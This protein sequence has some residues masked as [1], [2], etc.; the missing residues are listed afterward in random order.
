MLLRLYIKDFTIVDE[1][2]IEFAPGF[3]VITG[4]TGAGKSILVG[5]LGLL[6]GDRGNADLI[7]AGAAKAVLEAEFKTGLNK[8]VIDK[9]TGLQITDIEKAILVRREISTKGSSRAFINDTPVTLND[10]GSITAGLLDLHGQHQH[11]RLIHPEYH[12]YYLDAFNRVKPELDKYTVAY[13]NYFAGLEELNT[14]LTLRKTSFEKKDLY[15]FQIDELG[16]ASLDE[17]ELEKLV[18]ERR[19]M[20]NSEQLFELSK[21]VADMLYSNEDA[22]NKKITQAVSDLGKISAIDKQF[23]ELVQGLESARV[24]IEETG[25][26]CEQY[27]STLEFDP[28]RLET[29][30]TRETE[31]NWLLK[32]YQVE[33]V[34]DLIQFRDK[35]VTYMAMLENYDERIAALQQDIEKNRIELQSLAL[36]ISAYRKKTAKQF[37]Q[38]LQDLFDTVGLKK[39]RFQVQI[40]WQ[41]DEQGVVAE[42]GKR[43]AV[44]PLGMDLIEFYVGMN[45]G[46]PVR[47]LH[48]VASGGEISRIMLC[49]KAILAESDNISTLVFDE[50]DSGISGRYAEIVGKKMQEIA[51]RH[52]LIVI[53]HLP[54]IAAQGGVH[55]AVNKVESTGRT[56]VEVKKL[57]QEE[58]V[59]NIARLLG[60][61]QITP[62]AI[63]NAR[64][65]LAAMG[66]Y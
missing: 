1:L 55:F 28:Q 54:Q 17:S 10:L 24:T 61:E 5:A 40:S 50:I 31:I 62:Q 58:R 65:L 30:R 39:A 23:T 18:S 20:E 27:S 52:Q 26:F 7:R 47:P 21:T 41:E 51:R 19:I 45:V 64:V 36:S 35:L 8:E 37:E 6:C 48:R 2:A 14:L 15:Q 53:T 34:R 49:L 22:L 3:Q 46:E 57:E 32:K 4:E 56:T 38:Q 13:R 16:K 12:I 33:S 29:V 25:R 11:Q 42:K 43:Y 44:N 66:K 60:G 59:E 63:A 9:L